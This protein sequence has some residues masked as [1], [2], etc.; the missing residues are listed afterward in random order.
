MDYPARK[1]VVRILKESQ[2]YTYGLHGLP[3]IGS[4]AALCIQMIDVSN[5]LASR[6]EQ[7][8]H[9]LQV[10]QHPRRKCKNQLCRHSRL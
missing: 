9:Y 8:E 10:D 2:K 4:N 3:S 6:Y 5:D 1:Y 7:S